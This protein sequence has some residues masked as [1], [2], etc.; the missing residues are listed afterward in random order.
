MVLL[1]GEE[2]VVIVDRVTSILAR[3]GTSLLVAAGGTTRRDRN[4]EYTLAA[5]EYDPLHREHVLYFRLIRIG[6][7]VDGDE[8]ESR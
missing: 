2:M 3:D 5:I 1:E 4:D 7:F 8:E 6:G